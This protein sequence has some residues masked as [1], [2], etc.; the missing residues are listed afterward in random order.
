MVSMKRFICYIISTGYFTLLQAQDKA[1]NYVPPLD[2]PVMLS[3]TFGELRP[4][5]FHA[6]LDLKTQGRTGFKVRAI[7]DGYIYRIK[8]QRGGYGKA[9]YIKHPDGTLS[10]YA[11][12][13]K[14]AGDLQ[15]YV[16]R[17]QYEQKRFFIELFP[18][19]SLFPVQK[20]QV[21][22]Y[23]GNTGSS[24]G[25]HLHFEIREGESYPANPMRYGFRA[26]DTIA[27]VVRGLYAYALNDT[28][29]VNHSQ[30]RV[31]LLLNR[32]NR[33]S[34][35]SDPVEAYGEIGLGIDAYDQVNNTYNKNGVYQIALWVNGLKVYETRMDKIDFATTRDINVLIDYPYYVRKRRYIQRLWKHQNARLPV[36]SV[37]VN[38]GKINVEDGKVY[39]IRI[40]L[41]DFEGNTSE[42]HLKITGR[43][44]ATFE[45]KVQVKTPFHARVGK[46][47]SLHGQR[48]DVYFPPGA[49]YEDVYLKFSESA[50]GFEILP[51]NIPLRKKI[52][53]KYSLE[54]VPG[55]LKKYAYL[56]KVN[57]KTKRA[58][59]AA[60]QKQHDSIVF[61]TRSLGT[62]VVK[63]DSIPPVI[64]RINIKDGQWVSRYRYLR[65]RV[66]DNVGVQKVQ[67]Y[68]DGQWILTEYDYKTGKVFYDFND[69]T[70]EGKKHTLKIIVTDKVGNRTEKTLTF[71]RKFTTE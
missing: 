33:R 16:K 64:S 21:I 3:A 52:K 49:F 70:F 66:S 10:V 40:E 54:K 55:H 11:H 15:D 71:F 5:H 27:P 22:A 12:L 60:A 34:Y 35:R 30:E 39:K 41:S 44:T 57:P 68:I 42:V 1:K 28:S 25:P 59:Y 62:Y 17:H 67:A 43:K 29:S 9:V 37:L 18:A 61:R 56:A 24:S 19:E 23:S 32:K 4:H 36:F 13:E 50:D 53:I 7:A 20:G 69:L 6:G 38:G 26:E 51:D 48:V 63:Y 8:V 47:L 58:Y 2:L 45:K 65:F 31:K 14:F 46:P